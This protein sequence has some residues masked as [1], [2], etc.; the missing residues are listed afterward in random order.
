[1][2]SQVPTQSAYAFQSWED[3][4]ASFSIHSSSETANVLRR[5]GTAIVRNLTQACGPGPTQLGR[6]PGVIAD[7]VDALSMQ[8]A[9]LPSDRVLRI[10]GNRPGGAD[11]AYRLTTTRIVRSGHTGVLLR[12]REVSGQLTL[13]DFEIRMCLQ[14]IHDV[15]QAAIRL[16]LE[17]NNTAES[18]SVDD[19]VLRRVVVDGQ[20]IAVI[21]RVDAQPSI[22]GFSFQRGRVSLKSERDAGT[23][24]SVLIYLA[25]VPDDV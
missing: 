7:V 15:L 12:L 1:M 3:A 4:T 22:S 17:R 10:F 23:E 21:Q 9:E 20:G 25:G 19:L 13:S 18:V 16:S 14:A 6:A 8:L 24:A 2:E 11:L 5:L